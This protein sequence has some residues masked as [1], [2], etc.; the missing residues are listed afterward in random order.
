MAHFSVRK[1]LRPESVLAAQ[2]ALA[3]QKSATHAAPRC[4]EVRQH[5]DK[6]NVDMLLLE[7]AHVVHLQSSRVRAVT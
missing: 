7:V 1:Y 5:S 2:G 3:E 4:Q 6:G